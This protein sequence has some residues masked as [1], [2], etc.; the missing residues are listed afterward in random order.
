MKIILQGDLTG[1][2]E[3]LYVERTSKGI[4]FVSHEMG[5]ISDNAQQTTWYN[6]HLA[7]M[8]IETLERIIQIMKREK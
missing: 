4:R 7:E 8:S 6:R 1:E 3:H 5:R 2:G